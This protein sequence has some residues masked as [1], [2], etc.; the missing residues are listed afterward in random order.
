MF[1]IHISA[2]TFVD[3][4]GLKAN[5]MINDAGVPLIMDQG[6][7]L[8]ISHAEFTIANSCGPCRW[9]APE[10]L[11]PAEADD[12]AP[13]EEPFFEDPE[14]RDY[15]R[16]LFTP[17]S[18]VYSLGMTILE[19]MTEEAPYSYLRY[20]TVVITSVMRGDLPRKPINFSDDLW[21]LLVSCWTRVPGERPTADMVVS[22]LDLLGLT[23][24]GDIDVG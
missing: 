1:I 16:S 15:E 14:Y 4:L 24:T 23:M 21:S 13:E 9:I 3:N 19:V 22:W 7:T 11:E 2:S 17:M 10:I 6:L 20:D 12:I 5:V 18:D 8:F